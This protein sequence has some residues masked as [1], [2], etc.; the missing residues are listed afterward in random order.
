MPVTQEEMDAFNQ[1]PVTP[2]NL[3]DPTKMLPQISTQ[4]DL[5][6]VTADDYGTPTVIAGTAPLEDAGAGIDNMYGTDWQGT[7][8]DPFLAS[9]AAGQL[10]AE[11][12]EVLPNIMETG[13]KTIEDGLLSKNIIPQ[14]FIDRNDHL[15]PNEQEKKYFYEKK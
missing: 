12:V 5:G 2:A 11:E 8:T 6:E 3:Q 1:I 4:P 7:E 15:T 13:A 14:E 9:E 10:P